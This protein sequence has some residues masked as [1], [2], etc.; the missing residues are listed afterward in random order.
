MDL[1]SICRKL[2]QEICPEHQNK[3]SAEVVDDSIQIKGICCENFKDT[4][5]TIY[6]REIDTQ[7]ND[8]F[9]GIESE[10]I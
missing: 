6:K 9:G 4:I 8:A 3:V 1:Q 2:E 5:D 10:I 7:M